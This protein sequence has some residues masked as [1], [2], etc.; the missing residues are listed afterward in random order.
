MNPRTNNWKQK[1]TERRD[2]L[3]TEITTDITTRNP[4]RVLLFFIVKQ[5]C[6]SEITINVVSPIFVSVSFR[7]LVENEIFID[8]YISSF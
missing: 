1:R 5:K 6:S 8:F 3:H 7:W 4:E 2:R